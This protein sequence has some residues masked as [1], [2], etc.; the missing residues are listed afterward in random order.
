MPRR[1]T[2]AERASGRWRRAPAARGGPWPRARRVRR[3]GAAGQ[4]GRAGSSVAL[5][6]IGLDDARDDVALDELALLARGLAE[7]GGGEAVDAAHG[8]DSSLVEQHGGIGGEDL[9][10]AAGAL[11]AHAQ[12]LGRVLGR[13]RADFEAMVDARVQR[14][15][16]AQ[17]EPLA[18][19]G[20]SDEDEREQRAAVPG[21]VEQDVQM[22]EGVLVQQVGLVEEEH[23]MDTLGGAVLDVTAERVEQAARGG[24][25]RQTQRMAE[26]A[27]EVAA[28]ERGIVAGRESKAGA[29]Y[30]MAKR[31]QDAGLPDAGLADEHD[32]GALVER[33]EQR[34]DDGL[35]GGREPQLARGHLPGGT[36]G[37]WGRGGE[38]GGG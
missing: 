18:K 36:R 29:G 10:S 22:V 28:T 13:Q 12:I 32:R 34:V 30:A 23:G 31:A 2:A 19:L 1:R 9:A 27:V 37:P 5:P 4:V 20:Q 38:G 3:A 35:L 8:T 21:V 26:L 15:I 6:G 24:H 17:C 11:E 16:A 25:C 33:L 14:A 7:R